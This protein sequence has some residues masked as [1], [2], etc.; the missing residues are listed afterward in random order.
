MR[1]R[2]VQEAEAQGCK[3]RLHYVPTAGHRGLFSSVPHRTPWD[4]GSACGAAQAECVPEPGV[5]KLVPFRRLGSLHL[6][7]LHASSRRTFR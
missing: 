4:A 1:G 2:E 3:S 6:S 5:R 7:L